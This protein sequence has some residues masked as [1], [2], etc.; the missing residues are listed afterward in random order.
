MTNDEQMMSNGPA[1]YINGPVRR[2]TAS[3]RHVT[4]SQ[5]TDTRGSALD[6]I[7][8]SPVFDSLCCYSVRRLRIRHQPFAN[9]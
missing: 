6:Y 2:R 4:F 1:N 9:H 5:H 3:V 8:S 7:Q